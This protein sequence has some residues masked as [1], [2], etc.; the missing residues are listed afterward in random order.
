VADIMQDIY[1]ALLVNA[2]EKNGALAAYDASTTRIREAFEKPLRFSELL[3]TLGLK[4]QRL[5]KVPGKKSLA[6]IPAILITGEI[7]VRLN[8]FPAFSGG[9]AR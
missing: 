8:D 9:K 5:K 2:V 3:K 4:A 7:S 1:S 6:D